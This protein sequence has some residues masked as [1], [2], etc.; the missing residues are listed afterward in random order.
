MSVAGVPAARTA[1]ITGASRGIGRAIAVGLAARGV[2]VGVVARD[3]NRLDDVVA[4]CR[5]QG[6]T[7]VGVTADVT[8]HD[9]VAAAVSALAGGL[10]RIDLLVNNAGVIEGVEQPFL[11]T[12]V[13]E[14]WRVVEV[15]VRGPLLVTHA[16][17][18]VMLAGGGGRVVNLNSGLGY[19]SAEIYTGYAV[20]KGALAR[21]T[22]LLDLQYRSRG[23]R[24]FDLA[25]GHVETEMTT[26]MPMHAGRTSW[27]APSDVVDLVA[28]IGDGV[29]DDLGGRFFRAGTDTPESLLA[30]RDEILAHDAR[31]LRLP[32][33]GPNDPLS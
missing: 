24:A 28:A 9:D 8:D 21:F 30:L 31:A 23:V 20:S 11:D 27:T 14:T 16:V 1:L 19:R 5:A 17:L 25:P 12:E 7:A 18:P 22:G 32:T 10:D 3:R 4:E 33:A 26:A 6:A 2:S 13:E 15:N 29:L